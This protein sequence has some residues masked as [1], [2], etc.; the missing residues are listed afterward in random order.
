VE[1]I[2]THCHVHDSEFLEKYDILPQEIIE[3]AS[4]EGVSKFICVGT[5]LKSS[6]EAKR[7]SE[8]NRS[9][10]FSVALHPHEAENNSN[11]ELKKQMRSN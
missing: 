5:S 10:Y 2:D 8:A 6:I 11:E 7:F 9:C 3:R 4:V 1:Y